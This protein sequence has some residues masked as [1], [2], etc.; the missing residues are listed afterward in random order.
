MKLLSFIQWGT[1]HFKEKAR[2]DDL[3]PILIFVFLPTFCSW[4]LICFSI[5][6]MHQHLSACLSY[7]SVCL[8]SLCPV[9]LS[10]CLSPAA[11]T[12]RAVRVEVYF[13][14]YFCL[15]WL[16]SSQ[17]KNK[18]KKKFCS[19]VK[20]DLSDSLADGGPPHTLTFPWSREL[21]D[22]FAGNGGLRGHTAVG[23][24]PQQQQQQTERLCR[25]VDVF[26]FCFVLNCNPP[27]RPST[28]EVERGAETHISRI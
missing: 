20:S 2:A 27:H 14:V 8:S 25:S 19:G 7:L 26:L 18:Q 16:Y 21:L 12:N 4:A 28:M 24:K 3:F 13:C 23:A 1:K 10:V 6:A 22:C 11:S 5:S 9:C 15:S 17:N